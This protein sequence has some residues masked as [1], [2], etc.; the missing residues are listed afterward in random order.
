V[1]P[2]LSDPRRVEQ[3]LAASEARLRHIVEHAQDLI[4]Y[5]DPRGRFTYVNPAAARVMQYDE[6]ELIGRHFLTLIR[7]DYHKAAVETYRRQFESKIPNTYFEFA[8]VTKH[9]ELVW[10]GQHVQ[11]VCEGDAV[12]AVHAIA[13][14]ITRQKEAEDRLRQ[15]AARY[16]SL[17]QGAA[18]GIYRTSTDGRI[19]DANDALASMLGYDSVEELMTRR[20][21]DVYRQASEREELIT[22]HAGEQHTALDIEWKRK[23]GSP[24]LIH[25]TAR[26]VELED[27]ATGFEGIV[28]DVTERR[29]LEDQLRRA[30]RMEAVGRLAR[31]VAHDFNN[32]LAA[33]TG[34]TD[35]LTLRLA[36]DHPAREEAEE[37]QQAAERGVALT[38]QL[39]SF[40]RRQALQPEEIDLAVAV[41]ELKTLLQRMIGDTIDLKI[42][43][44][45]STMVR[46]EPSQLHQV[47]TNLVV[48]ARDAMP[49]G[50]SIDIEVTTTDVKDGD[51]SR[52]AVPAGPY[53]RIA[54]RDT[55]KGI[56][57]KI[58]A[59]VFEPFVTTKEITK[60]TGLGLSI[61][62]GIAK[63]W[64]GT[65]TF[66]TAPRRGTTFEVLIPL[67][68]T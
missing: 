41:P 40:S 52:Y 46:L 51:E 39:L 58:Q 19:L 21:T 44:D 27:G 32:V 59:Q 29:A 14:D 30:Q 13:R 50:G 20:M 66:T 38:K 22:R 68:T 42:R 17:I 54:V 3:A 65:V 24:I 7:P 23:D 56:D 35:L 37:I 67:I 15:S 57:P 2:N 28:E 48:N 31:G 10:I 63:D 60:G 12:T 36:P 6:R 1:D 49:K 11:L 62:Y 45:R 8:A 33:I 4:Y 47:L 43:A 9:G 55:G 18:Y 34:S 25:L 26:R 64:G 61:V 53:A 16:R 5:C